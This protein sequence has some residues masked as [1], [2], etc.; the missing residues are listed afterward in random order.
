MNGE[1][2]PGMPAKPPPGRKPPAG[3]R[4]NRYSPRTRVLCSDCVTTIHQLGLLLAP[5]PRPVRWRVSVGALSLLLCEAHKIERL[6]SF[7]DD[8]QA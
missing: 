5:V 4:V 7:H 2:L 1:P 6:E 3:V 8:D